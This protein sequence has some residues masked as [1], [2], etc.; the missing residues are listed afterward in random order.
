[1]YMNAAALATDPIERMKLVIV[2]SLAW[3]ESTHSFDKPFNPILGETYQAY[4]D[5]GT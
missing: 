3:I 4:M 1:M 2:S 5:D